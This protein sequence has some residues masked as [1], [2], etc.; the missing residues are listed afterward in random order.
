MKNRVL[1]ATQ[2]QRAAVMLRDA[3]TGQG[4]EV[5]HAADGARGLE[6]AI[7]QTPGLLILD[8]QIPIIDA[9]RLTE[10]LRSNPKTEKIPILFLSEEPIETKGGNR[11]PFLGLRDAVLLKPL[12]LNEVTEKAGGYFERIERVQEATVAGEKEI[13]GNL[14]QIPLVDLLQILSMNKKDGTVVLT[15]SEGSGAEERGFIYLQDGRIV[16]AN[17]AKTE[18]EKGL[19]RLFR[20]KRGKFEFVPQKALTPVRIKS[21]TDN[22]LMEGM[23]QLDELERAREELPSPDAHVRLAVEAGKIPPGLRAIS[24]E[25]LLLLE[26]Y[27]RV[28]DIVDHCSFP[29]LEVYHTIEGLIAKGLIQVA[30]SPAGG[31]AGGGTGHALSAQRSLLSAEQAFRLKERLSAGRSTPLAHE[32][33][34]IIV[35]AQR[36]DLARTLLAACRSLSGFRAEQDLLSPLRPEDPLPLGTVGTIPVGETISLAL[37]AIPPEERLEPLWGPF[38]ERGLGAVL[39]LDRESVP[40][41]AGTLSVRSFLGKTGRP[42]VAVYCMDDGVNKAE[43]QS[44]KASLSVGEDDFYLLSRRRPEVAALIFQGLLARATEG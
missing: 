34:R 22:L 7:S 14:S 31:A 18:G 11:P 29:D 3:L 19:Y 27:V 26:F 28:G 4:C 9:V 2:D 35:C 30:E 12:N 6:V 1:V 10:I 20:W 41:T 8:L 38:L 43:I 15:R 17:L 36:V 5:I 16:N 44:L 32:S 40:P 42:W 23:R 13:E 37:F 39:V 33:A 24:Q 25:V 21:P